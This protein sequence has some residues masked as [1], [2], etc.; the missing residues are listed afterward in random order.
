[1]ADDEARGGPTQL[2]TVAAT[3]YDPPAAGAIL[4]FINVNNET[5]TDRTFSISVGTDGAGKRIMGP[6]ASV[7]A[8][9]VVQW[10][11]YVPLAD[12]DVIQGLA[13]ANSAVTVI[14]GLIASPA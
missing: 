3:I 12:A 11:G 7:K 4:R 9:D 2:T 1:M 5:G 6:N 13:D 8:N 14:L 10:T